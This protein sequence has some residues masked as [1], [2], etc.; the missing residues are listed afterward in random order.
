MLAEHKSREIRE[1]KVLP[2]SYLA[3]QTV[4][5]AE[6]HNKIGIVLV[7][8]GKKGDLTIDPPDEFV[9]EEGDI[10]LGIG[11]PNEFEKIEKNEFKNEFS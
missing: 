5:D 7:G 4:K 3:G 2:G 9:I 8:I 10:I 6:I 11:K 1:V